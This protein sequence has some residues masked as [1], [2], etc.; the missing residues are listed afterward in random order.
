MYFYRLLGMKPK[1]RRLSGLAAI[2]L[3]GAFGTVAPTEESTPSSVHT[4]PAM[5]YAQQKQYF[6]EEDLFL[7][8]GY[9]LLL[10]NA[11]NSV[12]NKPSYITENFI[13]EVMRQ[14]S[15]FK[16]RAKSNAGA[17]G[18]M[19]MTR[20]AWAQVDTSDYMSNVYVPFKNMRN[21]IKYF[22]EWIDPYC[23][24]HNPDWATLSDASKRKIAAA[25]YNAGTRRAAES[26]FDVAAMP[27]ETQHYVRKIEKFTEA[28]Q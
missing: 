27:S 5:T 14:E 6:G 23:A 13:K 7:M 17:R 9:D 28:M 12:P 26:D 8:R 24:K 20:I 10:D 16:D 4:L 19:Q 25:A 3:A 18:L 22:S 2:A 11:Y 15:Q 1:I 21:G